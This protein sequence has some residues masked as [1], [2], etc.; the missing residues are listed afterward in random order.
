[1]LFHDCF[2]HLPVR[3]GIH[4][5][6]V[7]QDVPLC[8]TAAW[9][10]AVWMHHRLFIYEHLDDFQYFAITNSVAVNSLVYLCFRIVGGVS[11]G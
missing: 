6:S 8:F 9:Y 1:M 3:P 2:S 10:S 7:R 5:L 4:S 11:L